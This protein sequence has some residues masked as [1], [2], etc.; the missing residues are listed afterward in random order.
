MEGKGPPRVSSTRHH[1]RSAGKSR[2]RVVRRPAVARENR[3]K[4]PRADAV[5]WLSLPRTA[6]VSVC[7]RAER[8]VRTESNHSE[9][10][11]LE[12]KDPAGQPRFSRRTHHRRRCGWKARAIVLAGA[13]EEAE[14]P[15]REIAPPRDLA[16]GP[17]VKGIAARPLDGG[18]PILGWTRAPARGPTAAPPHHLRSGH[19][20]R[21]PAAAAVC[22]ERKEE[23]EG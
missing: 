2:H 9:T 4:S 10:L 22:G 7:T 1:R 18:V 3:A 11:T 16:S 5:G 23:K 15:T 6:E 19:H 20:G 14:P 12:K 13:R 17:A 21:P 8:R